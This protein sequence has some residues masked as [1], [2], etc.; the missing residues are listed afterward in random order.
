MLR[1]KSGLLI[2]LSLVA[3]LVVLGTQAFAG[4][5]SLEYLS[6]ASSLHGVRTHADNSTEMIDSNEPFGSWSYSNDPDSFCK[7]LLPPQIVT[8]WTDPHLDGVDVWGKVMDAIRGNSSGDSFTSLNA[9]DIGPVTLCLQWIPEDENDAP[10][11]QVWV[12]YMTGLMWAIGCLDESSP[13]VSASIYN[14]CEDG[15]HTFGFQD[16]NWKWSGAYSYGIGYATL[17]ASSGSASVDIPLNLDLSASGF[18]QQMDCE[19]Y[20][21]AQVLDEAPPVPLR[22]TNVPWRTGSPHCYFGSFNPGFHARN[23]GAQ[24]G[25]DP[26]DLATGAHLYLCDPDI[27]CYNPYGPTASYQ[28]NFLG[29]I[30]ESD[31][32][33]PG[34][35]AG[36][37]DNYDV[38]IV[39]FSL[40][41]A[42]NNVTLIYPNGSSEDLYT[43]IQPCVAAMANAYSGR[44]VDMLSEDDIPTVQL[45]SPTGAPYFVTAVPSEFQYRW[46]SITL[47]FKDQTQWVFTTQ[48]DLPPRMWA[49]SIMR[50]EVSRNETVFRRVQDRSSKACLGWGSK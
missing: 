50:D 16:T 5:W 8:L 14:S 40:G 37:V 36:W 29:L 13:D 35:S 12:K 38:R 21:Y 9:S 32:S 2:L 33:S 4:Q 15:Y 43:A 6:G 30:A 10:P 18:M 25:G 26:V 23:G 47:T 31:Y 42:L 28:R 22:E 19:C 1:R 7:R 39:A 27:T 3:G 45:Q 48:D 44:E 46:D 34:L 41:D 20:V 11:Q 49:P 24:S 17:N